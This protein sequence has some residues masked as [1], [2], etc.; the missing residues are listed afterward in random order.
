MILA[1]GQLF[2]VGHGYCIRFG[3]R[4]Y[5][6]LTPFL[7]ITKYRTLTK[8]QFSFLDLRKLGIIVPSWGVIVRV[9]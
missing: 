2:S 4:Q 7:L 1:F 6:V 5:C 3:E 9:L 8:S